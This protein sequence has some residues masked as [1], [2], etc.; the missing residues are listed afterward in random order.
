MLLTVRLGYRY[1]VLSIFIFLEVDMLESSSVTTLANAG[2]LITSAGKKVLIDALT[3]DE[4]V[5]YKETP[6]EISSAIL[7]ARPPFDVL[8]AMLVTHDH[9]DHFDAHHVASFLRER[10]SVPLFSTPAVI[11]AVQA[12]EPS[13]TSVLAGPIGLHTATRFEC[14][15]MIFTAV[16]LEHQGKDYE[17]VVNYGYILHL[18]E[19]YVHLGDARWSLRNLQALANAG[20]TNGVVIVP[21]PFLTLPTAF[22]RIQEILTPQEVIVVHLPKEEDDFGGWLEA[23]RKACM[24]QNNKGIT[25]T[26]AE[27][28]G[29][30]IAIG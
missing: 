9:H 22:A 25:V 4:F 17:S 11:E 14:N 1:L 29:D 26:L 6:A 18:D 3:E 8:T 20:G 27:N 23:A 5:L 13:V 30:V 28:I 15:G 16:G 2:V 19:V 21:F 12:H 24:Q 7:Q 10:P